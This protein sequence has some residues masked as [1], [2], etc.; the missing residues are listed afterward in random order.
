[1]K[2]SFKQFVLAFLGGFA[3]VVCITWITAAFINT[4][5]FLFK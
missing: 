1:M 3:V 5:R 2:N 4:L